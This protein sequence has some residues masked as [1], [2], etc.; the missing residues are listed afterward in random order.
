MGRD[1]VKEDFAFRSPA[2]G[3][4]GLYYQWRKEDAVREASFDG[5]TPEYSEHERWF[6]NKMK[7]PRCQMYIISVGEQ[8]AGQVRF[9]NIGDRSVISI[10][11]AAGYRGKRLGSKVISFFSRLMIEEKGSRKV[12]A[13]I[14]KSNR[15]SI[16]AFMNSGYI[17]DKEVSIKGQKAVKLI[18]GT[19]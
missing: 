4:C 1:T 2:I 16:R 12:E 9:E 19:R 8:A 17:F 10:S 13:Y 7:D 14:K 6:L 3:D 5:K 11:I 15:A 18:Y